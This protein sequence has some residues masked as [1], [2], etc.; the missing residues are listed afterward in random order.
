MIDFKS[1]K[2]EI[3]LKVHYENVDDS[4][5]KIRKGFSQSHAKKLKTL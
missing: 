2:L 5:A 1:M 3:D 4:N